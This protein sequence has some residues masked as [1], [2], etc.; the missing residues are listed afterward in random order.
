MCTSYFRGWCLL[1]LVILNREWHIHR[2]L[3]TRCTLWR[4]RGPI[5]YQEH[6][7]LNLVEGQPVVPAE[8]VVIKGSWAAAAEKAT[9]QPLVGLDATDGNLWFP[10]ASVR[11]QRAA[12]KTDVLTSESPAAYRTVELTV[13]CVD[14]KKLEGSM[15]PHWKCSY[16]YKM[17]ASHVWL[18]FCLFT[19]EEVTER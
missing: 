11:A 9:H 7:V 1:I 5:N 15:S 3:H 16:V 10:L 8:W 4:T 17:S 13:D 14:A 18:M 12:S 6:A 2:H 19:K